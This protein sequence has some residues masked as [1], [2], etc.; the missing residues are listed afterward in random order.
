MTLYT[1]ADLA[2]PERQNV[3]SCAV[4]PVVVPAMGMAS[5]LSAF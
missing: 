3:L 2:C 1:R 4:G 5:L